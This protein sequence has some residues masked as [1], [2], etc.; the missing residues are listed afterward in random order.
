MQAYA[1]AYMLSRAGRRTVVVEHA[2]PHPALAGS[3]GP[4]LADIILH[5]PAATPHLVK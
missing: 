2:A 1:A 4:R 5:L 3:S